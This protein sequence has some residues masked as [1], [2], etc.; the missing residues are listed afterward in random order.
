MSSEARAM[1]RFAEIPKGRMIIWL[2]V[3]GELVIFGG[4]IAGYLWN[5]LRHPEW[6]ALAGQALFWAGAVNTVVL[7]V[8]SVCIVKAH[9]AAVKRDL[10]K[11]QLFMLA[12]I[13]LGLLFIVFKSIEWIPKIKAHIVLGQVSEGAKIVKGLLGFGSTFWDYY[14]FMTGLHAVHVL[15]GMVS[16]FIVMLS[17][18][19]GKNLHRVEMAGIY[20]HF[21]DLI[22][23]FLF[24]LFYVS[25]V[26]F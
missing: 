19:K 6:E 1:P 5:F 10:K 21:V 25:N 26:K 12:T 3:A 4:A 2:L 8:S 17:V 16:I 9:E 18:R 15:L 24:P 23:I 11:V 20:W 14:Y 22:W 13:V 7:L